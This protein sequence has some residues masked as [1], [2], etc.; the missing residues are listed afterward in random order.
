MK[1]WI[2]TSRL[3]IKN[4][5]LPQQACATRPTPARG[6][7]Q[8]NPRDARS[9]AQSGSSIASPTRKRCPPLSPVPSPQRPSACWRAVTV[10]SESGTH[11]TVRTRTWSWLSSKLF[12]LFPFRSTVVIDSGL[13]GSGRGTARA[14]DA[15]GTSTQSHTSPSILVN[16]GNTRSTRRTQCRP[17]RGRSGFRVQGAD[18]RV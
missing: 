7:G 18:C 10:H 5:L 14:E 1:K 12:M 11:K 3:S 13:V 4:S 16:E 9:S 8:L 15:Q 2:R 6:T 17:Q